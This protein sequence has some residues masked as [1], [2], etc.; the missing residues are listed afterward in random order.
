MN[1]LKRLFRFYIHSSIHV[2][3]AVCS[4]VLCTFLEYAIPIQMELIYFTFGITIV[5]YNLMKYAVFSVRY[6]I[7]ESTSMKAIQ[8]LTLGSGLTSLYFV[9]ALP[10]SAIS[11]ILPLGLLCIGYMTPIFSKKK[12]LRNIPGI[13]VFIIGFVWTGITV[14]LPLC[15]GAQLHSIDIGIV[16]IQRFLFIIIV[17]LPFEIRDLKYDTLSLHTIPQCLGIQNTKKLGFILLLIFSTVAVFR[18]S[19]T[20]PNFITTGSI[21]L[22]TGAFLWRTKQVQ[23]TYFCSFGVESI[24]ILWCILL[25][26]LNTLL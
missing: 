16:S 19:V 25:Y 2:A 5:A 8:V 14:I 13:K 17:M 4:L 7:P 12:S 26:I 20:L 24:A 15:Y 18:T 23:P 10:L 21:V 3:I 1:T 6:H 9:W 11:V 22:I